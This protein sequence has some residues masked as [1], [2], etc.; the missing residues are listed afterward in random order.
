MRVQSTPEQTLLVAFSAHGRLAD[1]VS[2]THTYHTSCI[3]IGGLPRLF[4]I[5]SCPDLSD[6]CLF[7]RPIRPAAPRSHVRYLS[8][9]PGDTV[10]VRSPPPSVRQVARLSWQSVFRRPR[11]DEQHRDLLLLPSPTRAGLFDSQ[12]AAFKSTHLAWRVF[13]FSLRR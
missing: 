7:Q 11:H 4:P 3:T 8:L 5:S 13:F 2:V 12:R 6:T 1:L 10:R 9:R